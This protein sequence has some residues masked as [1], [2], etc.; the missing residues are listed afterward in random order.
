MREIWNQ[1]YERVKRYVSGKGKATF[2]RPRENKTPLYLRLD[3]K[4]SNLISSILELL[5]QRFYL[6]L[7]FFDC[8]L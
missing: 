7:L 6:D 1:F 3:V 5:F 8:V 4:R 2:Y